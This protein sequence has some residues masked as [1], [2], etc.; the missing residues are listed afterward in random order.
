MSGMRE[1]EAIADELFARDFTVG[2]LVALHARLKLLLMAHSPEWARRLGRLVAGARRLDRGVLADRYRQGLRA[3]LA[4]PP[5]V[6]RHVNA[7]AHM[8]GYF[9]ERAGVAERRALADSIDDF[10]C[11][12]ATLPAPLALVRRQA[13]RYGLDYLSQ[14]L[15]LETT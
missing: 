5:S 14:Q 1:I 13:A 15:Y 8:A 3:A 10:R 11:G 4:T 2:E 7:L 12:R 6:G 9:R